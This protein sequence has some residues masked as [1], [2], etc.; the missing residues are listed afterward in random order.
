M[1][2]ISTKVLEKIKNKGI[3]KMKQIGQSVICIDMNN[4]QHA[5]EGAQINTGL[6]Q[7]VQFNIFHKNNI[8]DI[9]RKT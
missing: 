6:V 2:D 9:T 4:N 3:R 7:N 8:N 5:V 1:E